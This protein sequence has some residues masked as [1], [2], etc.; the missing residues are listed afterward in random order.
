MTGRPRSASEISKRAGV[1]RT[2]VF[3]IVRRSR[4]GFAGT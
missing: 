2:I 3:A 1:S 4:L